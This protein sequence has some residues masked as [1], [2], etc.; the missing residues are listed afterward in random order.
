MLGR[1]CNEVVFLLDSNFVTG[2]D[3]LRHR[4]IFGVG[5]TGLPILFENLSLNSIALT[6]VQPYNK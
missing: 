2:I 5:K 6:R 4:I 3:N 1:F